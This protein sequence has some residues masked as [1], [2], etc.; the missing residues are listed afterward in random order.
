[1][2]PTLPITVPNVLTIA[3]SDTSAGAGVQADLKTFAALKTY[4]TSVITAVTAQNTQSINT[5]HPIPETVIESQI[6]AIFEDIEI[7]AVKIGMLGHSGVIELVAA[8]LR[9]YCPKHI[10]LDP[11]MVAK[12]GNALLND[13]AVET[14]KSE[15]FPLATLVTPNIPEAARLLNREE[16]ASNDAMKDT[17]KALNDLGLT[18]VLLKGGHADG[19]QCHD[20]LLHNQE[21]HEYIH[22]R[23]D[24]PNTHGTGCT[25]SSAITAQLA[26]HVGMAEAVAKSTDYVFHAIDAQARSL[27]VG[28]GHGPL[29]HF[30]HWW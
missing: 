23:I 16:S 18:S 10:V 1:M 6:R 28:H 26:R 8:L 29:S 21:V 11:V 30:Y 22:P 25:L 13:D 24:T 20:L 7:E 17:L 15:L 3:G 9:E 27:D 19:K 14:L 2:T 4:G 12:S 5:V